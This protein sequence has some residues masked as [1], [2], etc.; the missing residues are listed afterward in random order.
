PARAPAPRAPAA[1]SPPAGCAPWA[2]PA[3]KRPRRFRRSSA[4][5]PAVCGVLQMI[6]LPLGGPGLAE[7]AEVKRQA[8]DLHL[9]DS[10][11]GKQEGQFVA[12]QLDRQQREKLVRPGPIDVAA[13]H[14]EDPVDADARIGTLPGAEILVGF[15]R[16]ILVGR[17]LLI[18]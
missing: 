8:L 7:I 10:T 13:A 3:R 18:A 2:T 6:R 16:R 1:A 4:R 11:A 14:R 12:I 9:D 15:K 17:R 5:S